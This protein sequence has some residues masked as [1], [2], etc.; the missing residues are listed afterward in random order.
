MALLRDSVEGSRKTQRLLGRPICQQGF[1]KILGLGTT[2]FWRLRRCAKAGT[3]VPLDGRSLPK[4]NLHESKKKGNRELICEFL[5]ELRQTMSEAMPEQTL[6][7]PS[8]PKSMGFRRHT[9]RRPRLSGRQGHRMK[10]DEGVRKTLRMLPPGS[11]S[12][13]LTLFRS[14]YPDSKASL[15]LFN[16]VP[17]AC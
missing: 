17:F 11:F 16:A 3:A 6:G 15:K 5:E 12:D 14:R 10:A 4:T 13:Y 2:R 8:G 1:R 7:R 9:G